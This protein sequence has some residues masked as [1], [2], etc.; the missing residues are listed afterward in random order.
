MS[1]APFYLDNFTDTNLVLTLRAFL[2]RRAQFNQFL[3]C[4]ASLNASR[5]FRLM[6]L[7]TIE[8]CCTTPTALYGMWLNLEDSKVQPWIS[9]ADTHWHYS[10]VDQYPALLWRMDRIGAIGF[11]LTRWAPVACAFIFFGIFGFADEARRHYRYAFGSARRL[12]A[13]RVPNIRS[14]ASSSSE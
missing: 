4:N 7:A 9:W 13:R 3:S 14:T 10:K 11:E 6:T 12:L 2:K 8:L 1:I 5:Y